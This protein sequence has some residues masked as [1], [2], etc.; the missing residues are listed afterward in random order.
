M[1]PSRE[2]LRFSAPASRSRPV[3]SSPSGEGGS[4][5]SLEAK[6]IDNG[7]VD[8][9]A[10]G[11]RRFDLRGPLVAAALAEQRPC[12]VDAAVRLEK[13]HAR[14]ERHRQ[15]FASVVNGLRPVAALCRG[16]AEQVAMEGAVDVAVT[17]H[18]RPHR[19]DR[20]LGK[21]WLA[22]DQAA[23]RQLRREQEV[24]AM[25]AAASS[26]GER[27]VDGGATGHDFA[28]H[29]VVQRHR[30]APEDED[31]RRHVGADPRRDAVDDAAGLRRLAAPQ[32]PDDEVA[33]DQDRKLA[34][35]GVEQ[36]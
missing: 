3:K 22:R 9:A 11:S 20:G 25:Q 18:R 14:L 26:Q 30:T 15:P 24:E 23:P 6:Q 5:F 7:A 4:G 10:D 21:G 29:R 35:V 16:V 17:A 2:R 1:A 36:R 12:Q 8:H 34:V 28:V 19:G 33:A 27:L 32:E 31:K 13:G